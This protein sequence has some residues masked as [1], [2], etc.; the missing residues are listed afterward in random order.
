MVLQLSSLGHIKEVKSLLGHI[1]QGFH[2]A[3]PNIMIVSFPT[4][5]TKYRRNRECMAVSELHQTNDN[6]TRT[7][8]NILLSH[9][10]CS[11]T[12]TQKHNNLNLS[13]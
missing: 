11:R 13:R 4:Q 10:Y 2:F 1:A 5:N 6:S 8:L 12:R 9:Q 7:K 3:I